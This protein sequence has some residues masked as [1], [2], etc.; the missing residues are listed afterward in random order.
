MLIY[1]PNA[2]Q[3]FP[4]NYDLHLKYFAQIPLYKGKQFTLMLTG[5]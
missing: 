2:A 1:D 5:P 4:L 3:L